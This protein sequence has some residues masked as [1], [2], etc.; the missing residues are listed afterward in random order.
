MSAVFFPIMGH[1]TAAGPDLPQDIRAICC[2]RRP[3]FHS[4]GSGRNTLDVGDCAVNDLKARLLSASI[5]SC[6]CL[7]K[8]PEVKY[9]STMCTYRLHKESL[10]EIESLTT[11]R[12]KYRDMAVR[13]AK[14]LYW[15]EMRE[16]Q[17]RNRIPLSIEEWAKPDIGA[18]L[19]EEPHH[20]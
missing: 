10:A 15:A 8:T 2:C 7:T 4:G 14:D 11:E 6:T 19:S 18:L 17:I 12:D 16:R 3:F 13:L 5:G 20:G 9:H 1:G